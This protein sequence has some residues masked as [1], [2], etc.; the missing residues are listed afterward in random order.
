MD[1]SEFRDGRV[2]FRKVE[3]YKQKTRINSIN[4]TAI[5]LQNR[6]LPVVF[7]WLNPQR[8]N[9]KPTSYGSV[10]YFVQKIRFD[11]SFYLK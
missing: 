7:R 9:Q 6:R 4:I 8:L 2:H 10:S 3:R 5:Y 11:I 1:M